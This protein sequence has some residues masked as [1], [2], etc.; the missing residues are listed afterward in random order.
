MKRLL[1]VASTFPAAE[2]DGTP[3]F[4]RDLAEYESRHFTTH[5]LVPR[6]PGAP[7]L[8]RCGGLTVARFPYY[9]RGWE[10]L[11]YGAIIENVRT[12]PAA[13]LPQVPAFLAAEAVA[14]RRAV[15]R[16]RP[17]VVHVHWMVPQGAVALVAAPGVPTVVT[18]LGGDVY[19]LR[20]PAW[21]WLKGRVLAKA[22]AVTTMNADMRDRLV[23]L[24]ADPATTHVL[25]MGADVAAVRRYGAGVARVPGRILVAGRLVE[26]K[27]VDVLLGALRTLEPG[28]WTL[29]VVGDGPLRAPLEAAAAGLP[30]RFR[31]QRSREELARS[32]HEAEVVVVPSVPAASGDQD[33]LPVTLLEAMGA[34]CAIVASRL[35]GLDEAIVDGAS[36]LLV[37]PGDPVA[38]AGA[39]AGLLTDPGRR[40]ALGEA[41]AKRSEQFSVETIGERYADLLRAAAGE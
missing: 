2:G 28:G 24:G 9:P 40:A 7:R 5:V 19:A 35:A 14:L 32:L 15:R 12:N 38:L 1:V 16:F 41:A 20:G 4:V 3:P 30:V 6:V 10:T 18:T 37:P 17:D 23:A 34:G 13:A 31:G 26:K 21:R 36:G 8:E 27:G 39:L 25:P 33:G 22:R 29:D 11:A